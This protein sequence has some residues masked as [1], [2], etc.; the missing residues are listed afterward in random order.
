MLEPFVAPNRATM[1]V[2]RGMRLE[3]HK[4]C[5]LTLQGI[6]Y[7]STRWLT[8][9][10]VNERNL[11]KLLGHTTTQLL[12]WMRAKLHGSHREG[13]WSGYTVELGLMSRMEIGKF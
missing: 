12:R 9:W 1:R 5:R 2:V 6:Q 3:A 13:S 7:E 8:W 4:R 10:R 11:W